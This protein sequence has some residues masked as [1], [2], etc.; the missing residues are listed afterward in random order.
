MRAP[1]HPEA[2]AGRKR[3]AP[4]PASSR[5]VS[6]DEW[7]SRAPRRKKGLRSAGKQDVDQS[8]AE[9][10]R[11]VASKDWSAARPR[12]FVALYFKM[13]AHVYGTEPAELRGKTWTAACLMAARLF[14]RELGSDVDRFVNFLAWTWKRE[15]RAHARGSDD[16]RRMGWRLQFSPALVTDYRV[17]LAQDRRAG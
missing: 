6:L 2:W 5:V 12:H 3:S 9:V 16:R 4:P 8:L 14:E 1:K 13:H 15:K 17:F 7:A 11:M 10:D